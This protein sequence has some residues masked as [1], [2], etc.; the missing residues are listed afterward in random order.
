M[1]QRIAIIFPDTNLFLQCHPLE[2]LS[3][4]S[5]DT[6]DELHLIVCW[7]VLRELDN[8]KSGTGARPKRARRVLRLVRSILN[9]DVGYMTVTST[10]PF[11]KLYLD[12]PGRPSSNLEVSLDYS[13]PDDELVGYVH[14]YNQDHP[15]AELFLL[16]HDTGPMATAKAYGIHFREIPDEWLIG[17]QQA[18]SDPETNKLRT[19]IRELERRE[20]RIEFQSVDN[21]YAQHGVI[22]V[23]FTVYES[24]SEETINIHMQ[25]LQNHF[26]M[27]T[28]F[29]LPDPMERASAS[30]L[31][32]MTGM[33]ETYRPATEEEIHQY[34]DRD[35]P[36]WLA[37][38]ESFLAK[39]HSNLQDQQPLP[40]FELAVSNVGT[41]P[42]RDV[43][44]IIRAQGDFKLFVESVS[45]TD[46]PNEEIDN[47]L[48]LPQPPEAPTGR[49]SGPFDSLTAATGVLAEFQRSVIAPL[50]GEYSALD[51]STSPVSSLRDPNS[52]YYRPERP[53]E[54]TDSFSLVC[55]QWR[56]QSDTEIFEGVIYFDFDR[57]EIEGAITCEVHAENLSKPVSMTVPV[58]IRTT[59]IGTEA[60]S[61]DLMCRLKNTPP[62]RQTSA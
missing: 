23:D 19:R 15:E 8:I 13:K 41:R 22:N 6:Y 40:Y 25:A 36:Q 24:L 33:R 57:D 10:K 3:W 1:T 9:S 26:P 4:S 30:F 14:R 37:R 29:G 11:V 35:Y 60:T 21:R 52:F 7:S 62:G 45:D 54:P 16:T 61:R 46:E 20:P 59:R 27:Q 42:A 55:T 56:H 53:T 58:R 43:L 38:C 39:L 50:P 51:W 17:S 32:R 49:W 31:G 2:N 18:S 28:E 47:S 12:K 48:D 44:V 5:W 34:Q